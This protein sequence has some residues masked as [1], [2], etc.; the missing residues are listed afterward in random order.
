MILVVEDEQGIVDFVARGLRR[1]G[2]DV[3]CRADGRT[4]LAEALKPETELV[5]L[6]LTLPELSGTELMDVLSVRR[7]ELPVIMLTARGGLQDRIDGLNSGAVDYLVKPFA[8][9]ELTARV[10]AH[11]RFTKR[12]ET[13]L[14][15]GNLTVRLISRRVSARDVEVKLSTTEFELLVYLMRNPGRVLGREQILRAVWGYQHD[16]GTNLLD[17]YVGYVRRKL[18]KAG[19][20]SNIS[21]VRS[22]GYR[23]DS[24]AA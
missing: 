12:D 8:L 1:A 17:V 14:S 18:T 15:C 20:T 3:V 22:L 2:F 10:Q 7:P 21:T 19:A 13:T 9:E 11:M 24:P 5:V 6:D 16:P 23:F 4:G